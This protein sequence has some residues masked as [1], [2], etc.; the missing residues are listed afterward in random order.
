MADEEELFTKM[1]KIR[2]KVILNSE[3]PAELEF[4]RAHKEE[5]KEYLERMY[6]VWCQSPD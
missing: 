3:T 1:E 5:V 2:V 4:Y 6:R